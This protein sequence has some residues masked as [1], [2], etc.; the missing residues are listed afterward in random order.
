[1]LNQDLN[2]MV[3]EE[4]Q[5]KQSTIDS[6][7]R[8][9]F[10]TIEDTDITNY[11]YA[12]CKN[13]LKFSKEKHASKEMAYAINLNTLD[14]VGTAFG[15]SRTVNLEPLLSQ[16]GEFGC[17]YIVLHNHPSNNYFSPKDMNTFFEIVNISILVV[18]GNNGAVYVIEKTKQL[19][20]GD[21]FDIKKIIIKYRKAEISFEEVI[22]LL[23]PFGIVYN[24]F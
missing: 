13:L 15:D 19:S 2:D 5:I 22:D 7:P 17:I 20:R 4:N 8:P 10:V 14:F 11:I 6:L 16:M 3:A 12:F 24:Q 23:L 21:F 1:M 9:T 18:I